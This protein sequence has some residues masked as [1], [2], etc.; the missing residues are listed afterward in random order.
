MLY[1]IIPYQTLLMQENIKN[2]Y[3]PYHV[4]SKLFVIYTS[5][6][7]ITLFY[8]Q[9]KILDKPLWFLDFW[10]LVFMSWYSLKKLSDKKSSWVKDESIKVLKCNSSVVSNWYFASNTIL[11]CFSLLFLIIDLC[12]L[13]PAIIKQIFVSAAELVMPTKEAKP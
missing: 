2:T 10:L 13:I 11:S 5:S 1:H 12:N 9:S 6:N 7:M 4:E 8:K 3:K